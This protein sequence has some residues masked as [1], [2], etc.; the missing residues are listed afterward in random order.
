M[1]K[2]MRLTGRKAAAGLLAC[3]LIVMLAACGRSQA[4]VALP[5]KPAA[6]AA[7]HA[8]A[9]AA[10]GAPSARQLVVAAYEG[11]WTATNQAINSRSPA[12]ARAVLAAHVPVSAVPKLV[13]G[14]AVLWQRGEMA[15][16]APVFH[17][18]GVRLTGAKTAAV[19]DC[20]DLS[21]TGFQNRRT[22]Q[23]VGGLGQSHD[24]LITT[25]VLTHGRWLVTGAIPVVEPCKY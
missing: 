5:K 12:A 19:H 7:A 9:H 8:L 3:G 13:A 1:H 15:F 18:R 17:I 21:H 2:D 11:Y 14:M 24:Y 16:G 22:G 23:I 10:A 4:D 20:I 6:P 25:L